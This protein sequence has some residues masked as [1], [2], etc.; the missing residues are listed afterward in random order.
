MKTTKK[1]RRRRYR[2]RKFNTC[3]RR[4]DISKTAEDINRYFVFYAI[5]I[6]PISRLVTV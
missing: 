1:M 3:A 6:T 4:F 5:H 2:R